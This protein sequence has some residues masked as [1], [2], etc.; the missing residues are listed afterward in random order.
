SLST[1]T[2]YEVWRVVATVVVVPAD[3][4]AVEVLSPPTR[5]S[6]VGGVLT[7]SPPIGMALE[8]G[9]APTAPPKP[10]KLLAELAALDVRV[11][12]LTMK[13]SAP[14]PAVRLTL[15]GMLKPWTIRVSL[16]P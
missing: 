11:L 10:W 1:T 9:T 2:R 8:P 6:R 14:L 5:I 3:T 15:P 4:L 16:P 12:L 13:V 7:G